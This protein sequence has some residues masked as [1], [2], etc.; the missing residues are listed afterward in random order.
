MRLRL[1]D[2]Y[3]TSDHHVSRGSATRGLLTRYQG[4]VVS[5]VR[6]IAH[7]RGSRGPPLLCSLAALRHSTGHLLNCDTR[8]ALG[9]IRDLCRGGL[10]ACPHASDYCVASSSR[11]VLT[12]LTSRLR[13]FLNVTTS[14]TSSTIPQAQY[15][16]GQS[17][18]ASRRTV[19]PA[20]DVLRTSLSTLPA[21]RQGILGLVVTQALV[22]IDGPCHCLR[23][24]LAARYTNRRFATGNG[25]VLSRN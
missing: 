23:A 25:R 13:R 1:A 18:I 8:R 24:V 12:K 17:G 15:A 16:I 4:R 9:C 11:R 19:L 20:Q 21:K 2:K 22:T 3:A 10:A 7:G 14:A 5:A 6:G